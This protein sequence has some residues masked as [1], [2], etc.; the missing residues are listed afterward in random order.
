MDEK[1]FISILAVL[2]IFTSMIVYS[3]HFIIFGDAEHILSYF[4]LHLAFVPIEVLLVTIV[5]ERIL[6]YKEKNEKLKK[7]NMVV[8]CFFNNVG[9]KLLEIILEGD[10][11][12][13]RDYLKISNDWDDKKYKETKKLLKNF[14][15]NIDMEKIDLNKLKNFLEKNKEFLLR[16]MENPVLLE[17]EEFTELLMAVFHLTDE[18]HR[19][20]NL[21]NLPKSDLEHLKNDIIRAYKLLVIQW[22]NYLIH[23]KNNY[24]YLYSVYLRTNPFNK[25]SA[26][27]YD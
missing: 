4:L 12:N 11:G 25:K 14:N 5:I 8:G 17:H 3:I 20:E 15:Y 23:L 19:R 16:L 21:N 9:E 26:V 1:K 24:P 10:V 6:D 18:L 7:L 13:I 2:L 22:L 27:V